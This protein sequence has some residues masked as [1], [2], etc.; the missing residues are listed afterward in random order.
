MYNIEETNYDA[1]KQRGLHFIHLNVNSIL[2]KINELRLIA[3]NT[4]ASIIG[5]SESKL[6][7]T[8]LDDEISID[9]YNLLRAD[10]SR[11]GGEVA[12]YVRKNLFF[13]RRVNFCKDIEN[14]FIDIFL[15]KS[16]ANFI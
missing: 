8:V 2:P 11:H 3:H 7:D 4:K 16:K 14:I 9:G 5:L 12:C 1:F 10:R 6:D 13:Y 15:P